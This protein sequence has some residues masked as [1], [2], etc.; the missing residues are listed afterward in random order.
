[1]YK[2]LKTTPPVE[3]RIGID[4]IGEGIEYEGNTYYYRVGKRI[5]KNKVV[6]LRYESNYCGRVHGETIYIIVVW[7]GKNFIVLETATE[8]IRESKQKYDGLSPKKAIAF[9]EKQENKT[10][11]YFDAFP[12][13]KKCKEPVIVLIDGQSSDM[14]ISCFENKI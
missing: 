6:S 14:C 8:N 12:K 13:C 2:I 9:A 1:M 4:G 5:P 10:K 3:S 7:D 11:A